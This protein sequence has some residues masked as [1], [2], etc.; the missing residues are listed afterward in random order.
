MQFATAG[1][2]QPGISA[3]KWQKVL[4]LHTAKWPGIPDTISHQI[5]KA[6][7]HLQEEFYEKF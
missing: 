1:E 3:K 5:D 7:C 6:E 4:E 2:Y